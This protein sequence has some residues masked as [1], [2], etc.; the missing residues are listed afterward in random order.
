M[1]NK[2]SKTRT[3]ILAT[4]IPKYEKEPLLKCIQIEENILHSKIEEN[5]LVI[6]YDLDQTSLHD[7]LLKIKPL[8]E[9]SGIKLN[10]NFINKLKIKFI[11]F[12]ETN[13]RD[14]INNPSGWH[15]RLQNIYL[16]LVDH[17]L[18]NREIKATSWTKSLNKD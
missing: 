6:Q 9:T 7:L 4:A 15:L 10:D 2:N 17:A 18:E 3:L 12:I 1:N 5:R 13:Q 14:N 16:G 11:C 8:L